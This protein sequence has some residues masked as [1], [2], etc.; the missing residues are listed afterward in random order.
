MTLNCMTSVQQAVAVFD[1]TG[2]FAR[3]LDVQLTCQH[4]YF[5]YRATVADCY[6]VPRYLYCLACSVVE[7]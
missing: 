3:A 4:S 5:L 7:P 1:N 2:K 6:T